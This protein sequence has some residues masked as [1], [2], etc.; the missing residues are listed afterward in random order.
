MKL[1]HPASGLMPWTVLSVLLAVLIGGCADSSQ[2]QKQAIEQVEAPFAASAITLNF[3]AEP[4]LNMW[5][6]MSNS[7]TVLIIQTADNPALN[8]ILNDPMQLKSLFN[9]AGTAEEILQVDRYAVMPGQR[10]TLHIDRAQKTRNI[11]VVAGYY[12]FP[13]KKHMAHF[14]IPV[15]I[16]NHGWMSNQWQAELTPLT[17][18]ILLGGKSM[19]RAEVASHDAASDDNATPHEQVVP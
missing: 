15:A 16:S 14:A 18:D 2:Q 13:G 11:A 1:I 10:N 9:G 17:A 5:N 12:P 3:T 7:C 6:D 4:Q 8:K 19:L